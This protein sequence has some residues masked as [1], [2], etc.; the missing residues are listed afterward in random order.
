MLFSGK[1]EKKITN[2]SNNAKQFVCLLAKMGKIYFTGLFENTNLNE[3]DL[4]WF[5]EHLVKSEIMQM[6]GPH[7][8]LNQNIPRGGHTA[9]TRSA[10][11]KQSTSFHPSQARTKS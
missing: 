1:K 7:Q 9:F 2:C 4:N 5:T 11:V 6:M 3:M 10:Y 8:V